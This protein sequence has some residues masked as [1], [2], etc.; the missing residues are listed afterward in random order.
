MRSL[1]TLPV[2]FALAFAHISYAS[3]RPDH[4][5]GRE[6]TTLEQARTHFAEANAELAK[7]LAQQELDLNDLAQVHELSYTMEN[8]LERISAEVAQMAIELEAVH[9]ASEHADVQTV[10]MQGERYLARARKLLP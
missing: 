1:I 3:E 4:Y 5:K 10:R 7:L 2:L 6:S 9:V 8:A